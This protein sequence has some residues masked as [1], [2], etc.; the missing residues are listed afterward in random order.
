MNK[1]VPFV[2]QFCAA[3]TKTKSSPFRALTSCKLDFNLSNNSSLVLQ[4]Q[5]AY[6]YQLRQVDHALIP[7]WISLSVNIGNSFNLSAPSKATGY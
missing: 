4:L 7:C 5:R 2:F 6:H 3:S 1:T